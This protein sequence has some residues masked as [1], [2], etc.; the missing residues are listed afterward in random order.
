MSHAG[1]GLREEPLYKGTLGSWDWGRHLH[2]IPIHRSSQAK[3]HRPGVCQPRNFF[4]FPLVGL[5]HPTLYRIGP[6]SDL[7]LLASP[8]PP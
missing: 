5:V 2:P 7:D 3:C 6:R 4:G 1:L 8:F